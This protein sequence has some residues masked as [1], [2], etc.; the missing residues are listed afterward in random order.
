MP[1]ATQQDLE[2]RFGSDEL[3]RVADRNADGVIDAAV[4]A[5]AIADADA[6]I[7]SYLREVYALPL[8]SVP[9]RLVR[10]ATDL[11]L[12]FCYPSN[13]PE[14]V[15]RRR[16]DAEA[17]LLKIAKGLVSL[18]IAG[19]EPAPAGGGQVAVQAPERVFSRDGLKG[20]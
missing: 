14:D 2:D 3:K 1:Y 17:Y 20:F 10:L 18:D 16:D 6:L 4:V 5:K 7:D 19:V 9:G 8:A 13:P 11:A 15:Q 12:F